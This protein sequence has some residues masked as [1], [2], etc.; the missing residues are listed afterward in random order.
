MKILHIVG[1]KHNSGAFMG[2]NILHNALLEL[3][4]NSKLLNDV[5]FKINN[6]N[7]KNIVFINNNFIK[8]IINKLFIYFEKILKSIYLPSPRGTFTVGLFGFNIVKLKEYKEADIIHI[9][10]L[11]QGF[12]KLRSLSKVDKPVIWTMRDMWAFTG[13][14]HYSMEF[15]KYEV[16][17]LSKIIRNYKRKIYNKNF[18]FI[19]ISEW[20]KNKAQNS[21]VLQNY[22]VKR[23][24]NNIDIKDFN[25]INK[26]VARSTLKI[27]TKKKII[28]YGA[29]NPQSKRKGWDIFVETLKKLD[30]S[31]YFLLIFG[32]FWSQKILDNIGIEYKILGFIDNKKIM[33]AAYSSADIF[34]ASSIQEA[35]GKTFAEAMLCE[36]PVVCFD[37]TSISEI[38]D[39]K[40]NGYIVKNQNSY[41]L[42]EGIDWMSEEI[43]KKN[44]N[45]DRARVKAID[46]D[47]KVI[48]KE[49]IE[50]YKNALNKIK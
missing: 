7:I 16:S 48:A 1:G 32:N 19:A 29:Q 10:W 27:L 46:F 37:N 28:L 34:V 24:Y 39:H 23:I 15:E 33:N 3:D 25:L 12:I 44:Y 17:Y 36:T 18:Q 50:L 38:V 30:K 4:V 11:N 31:K 13:G 26:G 47:A 9:H 43:K 21:S 8:R 2:A 45:K 35:F 40:I 5:P 41:E 42:K 14:S 20:L 49:Y 22:K 6:K